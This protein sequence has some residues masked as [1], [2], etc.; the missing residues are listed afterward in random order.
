MAAFEQVCQEGFM[1]KNAHAKAAC[2]RQLSTSYTQPTP[3]PPP[4]P[5][6]SPS[7][8]LLSPFLSAPAPPALERH[9]TAVLDWSLECS[10]HRSPRLGRYSFQTRHRESRPYCWPFCRQ[11]TSAASLIR[12]RKVS[13]QTAPNLT[14]GACRSSLASAWGQQAFGTAWSR[15]VCNAYAHVRRRCPTR[16]R[17]CDT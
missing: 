17:A 16:Q 5:A 10:P 2:E 14:N 3:P 12:S 11:A 4:P 15:L 9:P 7:V 1:Q 13:R 8:P 6:P